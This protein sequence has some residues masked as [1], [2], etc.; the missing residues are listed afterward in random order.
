MDIESYKHNIYEG[1]G[2]FNWRFVIIREYSRK[3]YIEIKLLNKPNFISCCDV[4]KG[5]AVINLEYFK[6]CK[7]I[8]GNNIIE[9][10]K[11]MLIY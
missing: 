9:Y 11:I 7:I 3:D 6:D 8:S 5:H 1:T 4:I 10:L 2:F